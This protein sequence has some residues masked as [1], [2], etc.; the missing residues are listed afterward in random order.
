MANR[1]KTIPGA[2]ASVVVG[3]AIAW[4]TL[5]AFAQSQSPAAAAEANPSTSQPPASTDLDTNFWVLVRDSNDPDALRSYLQSFPSG[6]FAD[7]ARQRLATLR[8]HVDKAP[9]RNSDLELTKTDPSS[10][11]PAPAVVPPASENKDLV[12]SLQRELKRVGCLEGEADGVWGE[13][14]RVAL[15][16]FARHAKLSIASDEPNVAAL[17]AASA[18]RDRVCPL[19]CDD[20]EKVVG[21]RCVPVTQKK[22]QRAR[23]EQAEER[24]PRRTYEQR[25]QPR[26]SGNSGKRICFGPRPNEIVTCP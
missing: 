14:S 13:K 1:P 18:K 12:R 4:C 8:P 10:T 9:V 3:L 6:K 17:D 23:Q 24:K 7:E 2:T 5:P 19:V 21:D 26:E 25:A 11:P 16:N 22:P 20:G 15:K